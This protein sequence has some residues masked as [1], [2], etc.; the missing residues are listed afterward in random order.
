MGNSLTNPNR[1]ITLYVKGINHDFHFQFINEEF[2]DI[3]DFV[4]N[5]HASESIPAILEFLGNFNRDQIMATNPQNLLGA[6][7]AYVECTESWKFSSKMG[8]NHAVVYVDRTPNGA[9]GY[10]RICGT[11]EIKSYPTSDAQLSDIAAM[12]LNM[13]QDRIAEDTA[14]GFSRMKASSYPKPGQP[15]S[16]ITLSRKRK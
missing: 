1:S 7:V 8:H 14:S 2:Q 5:R 13:W 6:L 9:V 16:N 12:Y 4:K 3:K 15:G 10:A 11:T